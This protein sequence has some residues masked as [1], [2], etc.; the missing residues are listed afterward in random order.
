MPTLGKDIHYFSQARHISHN[1]VSNYYNVY[2]V[3]KNQYRTSRGKAKS[4][5]FG[6]PRG[7]GIW[8]TGIGGFTV[9]VVKTRYF[10]MFGNSSD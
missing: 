4:N 8:G 9:L 2:T 3:K 6:G 7:H 10:L 1:S 5:G